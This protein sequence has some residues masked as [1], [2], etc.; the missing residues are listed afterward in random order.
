MKSKSTFPAKEEGSEVQQLILLADAFTGLNHALNNHLNAIVLQAAALQLRAPPEFKEPLERIRKEGA[1]AANLFRSLSWLRQQAR[2]GF[3]PVDLGKA[4]RAA[5]AQTPKGLWKCGGGKGASIPAT[6]SILKRLFGYL[7][8]GLAELK[9]E[10]EVG[11]ITL[12]KQSKIF[13]HVDITPRE[14]ASREQVRKLVDGQENELSLAFL[15]ARS[16]LRLVDGR[17]ERSE[18]APATLRLS[19]I[20]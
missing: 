13:L 2:Q 10:G 12:S 20:W 18:P 8:P 17:M 5:L 4:L 19:L 6:P 16:L 3:Q 15:A 9:K 1:Q 11:Q 14:E 7:L